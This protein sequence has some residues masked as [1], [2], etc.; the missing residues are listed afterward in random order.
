MGSFRRDGSLDFDSYLNLEPTMDSIV[1]QP[2]NLSVSPSSL[3]S[4]SGYD[5]GL[6]RQYYPG[7]SFP[8]TATRQQAGFAPGAFATIHAST[9]S[10]SPLDFH[11]Q[12]MSA[13][14]FPEMTGYDE[15]SPSG[16]MG[17]VHSMET[18]PSGLEF[19]DL[20]GSGH[21]MYDY[22]QRSTVQG[23]GF[24]SPRNVYRSPIEAPLPAVRPRGSQVM[25]IYPGMHAQAARA[26]GQLKQ[27]PVSPSHAS[28]SHPSI[29][30]QVRLIKPEQPQR[31]VII[32]EPEDP[33]VQARISRLL[34]EMRQRSLSGASDEGEAMQS[35]AA[36]NRF[37]K[38][39]DEM[40]EDERLLASEE[41][42]KLSSKQRRQLRN[43]VS[44]R[45][46]R[47]RRKGKSDLRNP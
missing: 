28:G 35:N 6:T 12:E 32:K 2:G 45:A 4:R 33:M 8:Y 34:A 43:K 44:A 17:S 31:P 9:N 20:K 11:D 46:F 14:L 15:L 30:P 42:K 22:S 7:P 37:K 25:G 38:D 19:G 24:P 10:A 39:D 27:Q 18:S 40:D 16:G 3:S 23:S 1:H 29:V 26:A 5:S 36:A 47:S 41:G 21:S 13:E